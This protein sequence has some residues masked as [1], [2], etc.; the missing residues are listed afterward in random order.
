MEIAKGLEASGQQFVWV[1]RKEKENNDEKGKENRL[2]E[3]EKRMEGKGLVIRGWAP[4]LLI[5]ENEAI[6]GFVTHCG[7]NSILESVTAGVPVIT[8]PVV[9]EQFYNEKLLIEVLKI[10][11]GVGARKWKTLVGDFV[12]SE[13]IEKAVKEIMVG[14]KAMEMR[15][16][17]KRFADMAKKAVEDGGSSD[18]HLNALIGELSSIAM[19]TCKKWRFF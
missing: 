12:K 15:N 1:V 2:L 6:G 9:A 13:A 19:K 5:L 8:W 4:Q 3:F 10:E 17:A 16:R 14:E 11:V 18:T 7:W